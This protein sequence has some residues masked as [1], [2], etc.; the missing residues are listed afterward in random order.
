MNTEKHRFRYPRAVADLVAKMTDPV[1]AKRGF[2]DGSIVR[3]WQ[4]IV[5]PT[6]AEGSR[7][8][9]ITRRNSNDTSG[10]LVLHVANGSIAT[11]IQHQESF[12]R[13]R[14]NA[15]FGFSAIRRLSLVQTL[16]HEKKDTKHK[17]IPPSIEDQKFAPMIKPSLES[18][19]DLEIRSALLSLGLSVAKRC[20]YRKIS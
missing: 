3:D 13:D 17:K 16:F 5:G 8:V 19:D 9:R 12:I 14:I 18:I 2:S 15:Y 7:P 6:L 1:F 4:L 11:E 20:A 10:T